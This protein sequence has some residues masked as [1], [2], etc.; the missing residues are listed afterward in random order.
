MKER[1]TRVLALSHVALLVIA[2]GGTVE[3]PD[4]SPSSTEPGT[5]TSTDTGS[6]TESG[7]KDVQLGNC[8]SGFDPDS[9]IDRPCDWL[10]QDGLCYESKEEA[11]NCI[12]PRDQDSY[13]SS[14]FFRGE[15]EATPVSCE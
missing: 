6:S 5:G 1:M 9:E 7:F 12:C 4:N 11:C 2:C 3:Q 15:G 10:G 8:E 13:C 14:G